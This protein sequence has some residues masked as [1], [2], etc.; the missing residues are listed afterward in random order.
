M[1]LP[2]SVGMETTTLATVLAIYLAA[3]LVK[4]A[5]GFGLPL[6]SIG[7]LPFVVPIET[8]LALNAIVVVLTNVQQIAQGGAYR[9]GFR[10]AWPVIAAMALTV[11]LGAWLAAWLTAQTLLLVLGVSILIFLAVSLTTPRL[12]IAPE[13]R[14]PAGGLTGSAAGIVGALT[15]APG[16]IFVMY[17]VSLQTERPVYMTGLGLIMASFGV[18]VTA[19]YALTDVMRVEHVAPALISVP[20][21]ILGMVLGNLSARKLAAETFRRIILALLA[22]L[23]ILMIR[24]ALL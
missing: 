12:A 13:W 10:A 15:S 21:A 24:R 6:V 14:V 3:G 22:V 7:M 5:M 17:M 19:S 16:A 2:F 9:A 1:T 8:A 20:A 11:P 18:F 23:A 4:G